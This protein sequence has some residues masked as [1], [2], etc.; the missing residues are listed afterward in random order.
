M[1]KSVNCQQRRLVPFQ[2]PSSH[3]LVGYMVGACS[4][5]L[6]SSVAAYLVKSLACAWFAICA[7]KVK[8]GI[9]CLRFCYSGLGAWRMCEVGISLGR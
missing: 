9:K 5:K 1:L 4:S 7:S 2:F 6:M 3:V 8:L